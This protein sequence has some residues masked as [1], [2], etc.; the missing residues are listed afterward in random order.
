[1]K[2]KFLTV[3]DYGMG[4]IWRYIYA[5]RAEEIADKYPGL[6]VLEQEPDWISDEFRRDVRVVDINDPPSKFLKVMM[7]KDEGK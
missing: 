5:R 4:A 7:V 6:E 3:Y 2:T 1:M